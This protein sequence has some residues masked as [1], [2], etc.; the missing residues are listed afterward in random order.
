[1]INANQ[2]TAM[3]M[4]KGPDQDQWQGMGQKEFA[5][6]PRI[7]EFIEIDVDDVGYMYKVVNVVHPSEP[8][9]NMVDIY[10]AELGK[11]SDVQK[12]LFDSA[13]LPE[14]PHDP[15]WITNSLSVMERVLAS[16]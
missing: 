9:V 16:Y 8:T 15:T 7:G 5:V 1:M 4:V 2:I 11:A 14:Q 10:I 13:E 12:Q 3:L 6:L